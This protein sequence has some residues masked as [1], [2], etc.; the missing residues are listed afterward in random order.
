VTPV[1]FAE[2]AKVEAF[3]PSKHGAPPGVSG[4]AATVPLINPSTV[5]AAIAMAT[6]NRPGST[7]VPVMIP[8]GAAPSPQAPRTSP[9][10]TGSPTSRGPSDLITPPAEAGAV[11]LPEPSGMMPPANAAVAT[12]V[13][14]A[15]PAMPSLPQTPPIYP[16]APPPEAAPSAISGT[17]GLLIGFLAGAVLMGLAALVYFLVAP[18]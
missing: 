4:T 11:S 13:M 10:L 6:A 3:D 2:T 5:A 12:A 16:L 9:T 14:L 8:P 15:P 17:R 1:A 18:R 7:T